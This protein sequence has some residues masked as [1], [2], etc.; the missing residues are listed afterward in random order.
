MPASKT[1]RDS[2]NEAASNL[3]A[4]VEFL[5]QMERRQPVYPQWAKFD[6]ATTMSDN[7]G[8]AIKF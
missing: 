3:V 5:S 8:G 2:T 7:N 4:L 6:T 1:S